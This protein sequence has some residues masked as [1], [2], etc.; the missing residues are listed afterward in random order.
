MNGGTGD[1]RRLKGTGHLDT[2]GCVQLGVT[3]PLL[4]AS[5]LAWDLR[6]EMPYSGYES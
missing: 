5:G 3:G 1:Y 4:R 2:R 6:K